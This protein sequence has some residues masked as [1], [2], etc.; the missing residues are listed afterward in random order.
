MKLFAGLSS[1]DYQDLFRAVG[2]WIDERG[3]LELRIWEHADG[4]VLQGRPSAEEPYETVLMTDDD[5]R[6]LL[7]EAYR[8]RGNTAPAWLNRSA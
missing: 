1:S 3:L 2:A 8:R 6:E 5:L 4:L 7:T